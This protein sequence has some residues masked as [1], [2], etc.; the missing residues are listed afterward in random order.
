MS[1][2]FPPKLGAPATRALANAGITSAD[3][4]ATWTATE[5]LALHGVGPSALAPLRAAL[6]ADGLT[7]AGESSPVDEY[8]AG[9]PADQR[10][11]L[12]H[13]RATLHKLLPDATEE[14][15]YGMPALVVDGKAVAGFAA[16]K[17]HLSYF[18]MSGSVLS[19]AGDAVAA[20]PTSKGGLQFTTDQKLPV[21]L[22]RTLVRL[23]LAEL[24]AR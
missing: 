22:V 9:L 19:A 5:L 21:A 11:A 1:A 18:P 10:R 15:R 16:F 3:E 8:L 14:L 23:R 6:A 24:R 12:E 4:L 2:P 7:L 13:L 20:Y 17:N